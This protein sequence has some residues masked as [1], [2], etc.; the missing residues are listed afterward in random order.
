MKVRETRRRGPLDSAESRVGP[1]RLYGSSAR[2]G[3]VDVV[4]HVEVAT[5]RSDVVG[6]Q[7]KLPDLLLHT[8]APLGGVGLWVIRLEPLQAAVVGSTERT[9]SAFEGKPLANVILGVIW[10]VGYVNDK[11]KGGLPGKVAPTPG[12]AGEA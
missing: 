3:L 6:L 8:E 11:V 7:Q 4:V 9:S 1:P 2:A 10:S 5:L 12:N